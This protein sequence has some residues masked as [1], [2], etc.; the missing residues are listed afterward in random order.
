MAHVT[1]ADLTARLSA[2]SYTRLFAKNGGNTV[3]TTFRDL[4]LVEA[5]SEIL[6]IVR[7]AYEDGFDEAGGTVDECIKGWICDV[8]CWKAASRHMSATDADGWSLAGRRA[9]VNAKAM[10]DDNH[11]RPVTAAVATHAPT[12]LAGV[13][14]PDEDDA[15][16]TWANVA[17]GTT[18]GVF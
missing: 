14:T 8:A 2:T 16:Q 5:E 3:D 7:S 12:G 9:F 6:T 15:S 11:R 1:S 10:A 18:S 17:D 4:C 13:V